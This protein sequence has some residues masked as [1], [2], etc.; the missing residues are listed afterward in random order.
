MEVQLKRAYEA[1]AAK[2]VALLVERIWPRGVSKESLQLDL[3]SKSRPLRH[4]ASGLVMRSP[5]G[6]SSS[7]VA[8]KNSRRRTLNYNH[9]ENECIK[10]P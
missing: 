1:P 5:G 4:C 8:E 3:G 2:I 7:G 10:A 6:P 9:Y